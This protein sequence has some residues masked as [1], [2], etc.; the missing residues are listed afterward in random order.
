MDYIVREE[1]SYNGFWMKLGGEG[2]VFDA[3]K[4]KKVT[5]WV[6]GSADPGIPSEIKC[7]LKSGP[8][9]SGVVYVGDITSEWQKKEFNLA[10]F[11][12]QGIDLSHLIDIFIV[13]EQRKAMPATQGRIYVD[14][15]RFE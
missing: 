2:V 3:S 12:S 7:E 1:G 14:D 15:F 11:S 8:D 10:E 4:Y 6:K 9:K 13:F 5:F